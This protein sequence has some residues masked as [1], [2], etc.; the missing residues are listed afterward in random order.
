MVIVN[1]SCLLFCQ[2]DSFRTCCPK[3]KYDSLTE[4]GQNF[5]FFQKEMRITFLS[6][7]YIQHL[8]AGV[9]IVSIFFQPL[10][11][12]PGFAVYQNAA[13]SVGSSSSSPQKNQ[14]S[15]KRLRSWKPVCFW[16]EFHPPMGFLYCW[17]CSHDLHLFAAVTLFF[18]AVKRCRFLC[19]LWSGRM[20]KKGIKRWLT[21]SLQKKETYS[22]N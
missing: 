20:A 3:I 18:S 2:Y 22:W 16:G 21:E 14:Q 8:G 10:G 12:H 9:G 4:K 5:P 1:N 11:I 7:S 15:R 6:I 13:K 19:N 17:T